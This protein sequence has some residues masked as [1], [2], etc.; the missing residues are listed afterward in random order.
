MAIRNLSRGKQ[1]TMGMQ[2]GQA[3]AEFLAISVAMVPL[4]LLIPV[5]A[6]YQDISNSTQM[7]SRYVAFDAMYRNDSMGTWKPESQL[8]DEV[9]RRFFSNSD[10]PIKTNDVAGDFP[11]NRNLFW[12]DPNGAPLIASFGNNVQVSYGFGNSPNHSGAFSN[13]SDAVP[14]VLHNELGLQARGIYTA[15]VSV[16]L[17]NLPAGLKFYEPFDQINLSIARSTSLIFDPWSARN[18]QEVE[19]RIGSNPKLFPAGKLQAVSPVVDAA[20][21]LIDLPGNLSGPKLGKLDFW[22]DVVPEDRLRSG[23]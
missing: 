9:R 7:A 6:K 21:K 5:I 1:L 20:I 19:S 23:N 4:F 15:N 17:A 13:T 10:A 3:L 16:T 22:R 14:F 8:A 11:A 2:Q 18:P 12:S